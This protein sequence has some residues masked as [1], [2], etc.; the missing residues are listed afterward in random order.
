MLRAF[1]N[2]SGNV[3]NDRRAL[4]DAVAAL[5][6]YVPEMT[7]SANRRRMLFS[8][9]SAK[10]QRLANATGYSKR[11]H[12][13]D[14][15]VTDNAVITTRICKL[16]ERRFHVSRAELLHAKPARHSRV[17]ELL[18]HFLRDWSALG[19]SERCKTFPHII[20]ALTTEFGSDPFS[21]SVLV[22]GAGVGRLAHD[23]AH[24]GFATEAN[25]Y[26]HLM[27]LGT[28]FVLDQAKQSCTLYPA[29]HA[30]SYQTSAA[31]QL[32]PIVFPDIP[33]S[34]TA[35]SN[36]KITF[37]D[38]TKITSHFN[39][40]VTLFF[41]DTAQD[42]F[43]YIETIHKQLLPGGLW[44]NCGPLKYGSAP[45]VQFTL[46]ELLELIPQL[47]FTI[48]RRWSEQAEYTADSHSLWHGFY[49]VEGWVARKK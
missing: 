44:I 17:V 42:I 40:V 15:A 29:V 36:L 20:E 33:I 14:R 12:D 39:A 35:K 3:D 47:G 1:L 34:G 4:L 46:E 37:G 45:R 32:R 48:E 38:F 23:I 5:Q 9:L 43:T 22:P 18:N 27:H 16:A 19:A 6:N 25:E 21:R 11:L 30:F 24:L 31:D 8:H 49:G 13:V 7:A 10:H 2:N 41:I 26:S 28:L